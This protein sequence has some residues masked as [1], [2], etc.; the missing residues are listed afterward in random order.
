[1]ARNWKKLLSEVLLTFSA[2]LLIYTVFGLG[3]ACFTTVIESDMP[4]GE[5]SFDKVVTFYVEN[6]ATIDLPLLNPSYSV[7]VRLVNATRTMCT[8]WVINGWVPWNETPGVY[9]PGI[10]AGESNRVLASI[11]PGRENFTIEVRAY[12]RFW[13][14]PVWVSTRSYRCTYVPPFHYEITED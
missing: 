6:R 13:I 11:T 8:L 2:G 12:Y 14:L 10:K 4:R 3:L 5:F 1:M 7:D 9:L